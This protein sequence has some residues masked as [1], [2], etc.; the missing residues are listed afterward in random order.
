MSHHK[1]GLIIDPILRGTIF[2]LFVKTGNDYFLLLNSTELL[3]QL[4]LFRYLI[5]E[6][7]MSCIV[8]YIPWLRQSCYI[9]TAQLECNVPSYK[10]SKDR[11]NVVK[12]SP[13][14]YIA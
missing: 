14:M 1:H 5:L 8:I 2:N 4:T 3:Y 6:V 10:I 9:F 13:H 7:T 12:L 11:Y